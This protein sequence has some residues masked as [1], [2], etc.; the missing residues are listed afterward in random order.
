[1][2]GQGVSA[3]RVTLVGHPLPSPGRRQDCRVGTVPMNDDA[4][5]DAGSPGEESP[6]PPGPLQVLSPSPPPMRRTDHPTHSSGDSPSPPPGE[7]VSQGTWVEPRET[8]LVD[9]WGSEE[10][11]PNK[12]LRPADKAPFQ[13]VWW[14]W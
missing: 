11:R 10:A 12:P 5:I 2:A 13:P 1:M 4:S 3:V 14:D 9:W 6:P 7:T 8:Y